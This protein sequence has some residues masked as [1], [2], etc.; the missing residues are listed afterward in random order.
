MRSA[1]K[2]EL[3]IAPGIINLLSTQYKIISNK[4]FQWD[5]RVYGSSEGFWIFIEDVNGENVLHHE[6]FLLKR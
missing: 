6:F 4:D 2:V 3:S 1:L 5:E